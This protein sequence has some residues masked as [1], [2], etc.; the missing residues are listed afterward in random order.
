MAIELPDRCRRGLTC[1]SPL[2]EIASDSGESFCCVG[3]NDGSDRRVATDT[4]TLCI[5]SAGGID[6]REHTDERDLVDQAAV[7]TRALSVLS[8]RRAAGST[9]PIR[10]TARIDAPRGRFDMT[11]AQKSML[12]IVARFGGT[13]AGWAE[14]CLQFGV[15]RGLPDAL[16]AST[17]ER[18]CKALEKAGLVDA[19]SDGPALTPRGRA[20][21]DRVFGASLEEACHADRRTHSA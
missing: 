10:A 18:V 1:C 2:S 20:E 11:E 21:H 4:L 3:E 6:T 5:R 9:P 12:R 14:V 8:N 16:Y 17:T 15:E 19:A 13:G 7:I